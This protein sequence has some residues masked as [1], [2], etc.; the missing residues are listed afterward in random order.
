MLA[1]IFPSLLPRGDITTWR[2][3][4]TDAAFEYWTELSKGEWSDEERAQKC[5]L[6]PRSFKSIAESF[7]FKSMNA[8]PVFVYVSI[9]AFTKR[10]F[11]SDLFCLI[12]KLA[13]FHDSSFSFLSFQ[14][15]VDALSL[16]IRL[17]ALL[18]LS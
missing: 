18:L 9:H 14:K 17:S 5:K 16:S 4:E 6:S 13:T 12:Q 11:S 3:E 8:S 2:G 7:D 10:T 15:A 1:A